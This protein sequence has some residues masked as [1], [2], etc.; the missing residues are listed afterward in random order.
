MKRYNKI[1]GDFGEEYAVKYLESKGYSI[2]R[3]NYRCRF[4]ELDIVAIHDGC[5]VFLE[6]KTR[7]TDRYGV[8]EYAVNYW[9][10]KHMELS[11]R[12][13]IEEYHMGK[14]FARF[15]IVEVFAKCADNN[16]RVDRVNVIKNAF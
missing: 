5:L 13:Y 6:V 11:A 2:L 15:D 1:V 8:P 3:R 14:Y 7:T 4:G 16:F 10:R 9:K 12:C